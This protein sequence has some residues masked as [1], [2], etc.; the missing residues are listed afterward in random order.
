MTPGLSDEGFAAMQRLVRD[1][2]AAGQD[3]SVAR[4]PAAMERWQVYALRQVVRV[5]EAEV[6]R[7][8]TGGRW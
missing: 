5:A 7:R 1:L 6:E 3:P 8:I 4:D 2:M